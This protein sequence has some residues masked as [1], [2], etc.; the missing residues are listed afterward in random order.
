[1]FEFDKETFKTV[2]HY[3]IEVCG[4]QN[5]VGS[6][7]LYKLMYFI[8]F[9][10]YELFEE[11]L[12]GETYQKL[13]YGPGPIHFNEAINELKNEKKIS[14]HQIKFTKD[15]Y[16]HR[17]AALKPS[18][19]TNL[20]K[21]QINVIKKVINRCG[22]MYAQQISDYSHEDTPWKATEDAKVIDY[23]LVFY[24]SPQFSVRKY[25]ED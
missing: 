13:V 22:H 2:L 4:E 25:D 17:Y 11:P 8:D 12:T 20:S 16:Q 10:Y 5:N 23:E 1:M 9:D 7:V 24:R 3:I 21:E 19:I 15:T 14:H 18:N 6:T